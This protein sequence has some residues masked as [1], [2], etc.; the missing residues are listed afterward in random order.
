[1]KLDKPLLKSLPKVL[2]HEH[3]DGALPPR[4]IIELANDES[5]NH[6]KLPL[7]R[8]M[9]REK[10]NRDRENKQRVWYT[11][12]LQHIYP[13]FAALVPRAAT[14]KL[15]PSPESGLD[16]IQRSVSQNE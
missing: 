8:G 15:L 14:A 5:A 4:T 9:L 12:P 13:H 7:L 3:L 10:Q 16:G 1:M 6:A 11:P 2:L